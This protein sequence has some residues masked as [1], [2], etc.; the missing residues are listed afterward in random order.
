MT[1][2]ENRVDLVIEE[3]L[4]HDCSKEAGKLGINLDEFHKILRPIVKYC[5]KVRCSALHN[6]DYI[7]YSM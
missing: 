4:I 7:T 5:T 3:K 1:D 2:K 6:V